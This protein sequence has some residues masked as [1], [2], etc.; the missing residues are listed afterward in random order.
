MGAQQAAFET[1]DGNYVFVGS[2]SSPNNGQVTGNQ[3]SLDFWL[4]KVDANG[5]II[6]QNCY[7]G[8]SSELGYMIKKTVDNGI[9]AIGRTSSN[10][11]DVSSLSGSSDAWAVKFAP[12][13]LANETF[14]SNSL[15]LYPNPTSGLVNLHFSE[16]LSIDKIIL[17]NP[18]GQI[19][20]EISNATSGFDTSDLSAGVYLVQIISE[21]THYQVK[22]IKK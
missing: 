10:D 15:M 19:V 2:S 7:G 9:I 3:G 12:E 18:L 17:T 11:G 4:V 1:I 8:S 6:W 14:V 22:L 21:N 16:M 13:V 20:K 5:N